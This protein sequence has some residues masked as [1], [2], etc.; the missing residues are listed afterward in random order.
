MKKKNM[1]RRFS[2]KIDHF[3][4]ILVFL[5]KFSY[6]GIPFAEELSFRY[7]I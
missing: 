2:P 6:F 1:I 7:Q 3:I 5:M 4:I